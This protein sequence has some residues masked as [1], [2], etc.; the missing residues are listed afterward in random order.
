MLDWN[1]NHHARHAWENVKTV[2]GK[3]ALVL[4]YSFIWIQVLSSLISIIWPASQGMQ[5][6]LN[7]AKLSPEQLILFV[8]SIRGINIFCIGLMAYADVGGLTVKNV[9]LVTIVFCFMFLSM[10]PTVPMLAKSGCQGGYQMWLYPSWIL[11]ALIFTMVE[12]KL[13]GPGSTTAA[14]TQRLV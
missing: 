11:L 10:I 7:A 12:V 3:L 5:C 1:P 13:G 8:S 6:V 4:F 14:E 2:W 9:A